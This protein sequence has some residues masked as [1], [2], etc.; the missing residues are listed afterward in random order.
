MP[1]EA[2]WEYAAR[3]GSQEAFSF[4]PTITPEVV[5]YCGDYP[6]GQVAKGKYEGRPVRVEVKSS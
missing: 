2:E 5:N 1:N 6:Y 4:G 3:A